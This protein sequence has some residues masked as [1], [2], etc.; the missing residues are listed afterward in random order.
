MCLHF[1]GCLSS[2]VACDMVQD[3]ASERQG[4]LEPC[5]GAAHQAWGSPGVA[6]AAGVDG[7]LCHEENQGD[8]DQWQKYR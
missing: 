1:Y 4:I 7:E 3:R 6:T 2:H 5:A 8:S